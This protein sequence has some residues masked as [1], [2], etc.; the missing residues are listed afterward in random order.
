LKLLASAGVAASRSRRYRLGMP[1]RSGW[2]RDRASGRGSR[3]WS[4]ESRVIAIIAAL[5]ML[6][7]GAA[8]VAHAVSAGDEQEA[9]LP[10][11]VLADFGGVTRA[12]LETNALPYKVVATA[13][14]MREE[15][16]RGTT[17]GRADLPDV[18]RQFG[19][20]TPSRIA[21]WPATVPPPHFD[22]PVGM[23]SAV[24][25][26]PLPLVRIDA[27]NLGCATCHA[28]VL[29]DST[30]RPTSE[31]WAGFPNSSI[32]LE[33]Y[34]QAV[35]VALASAVRDQGAFRARVAE[36][37]PEM[38]RSERITLRFFLLPRVARRIS[39]LREAGFGALPFSNGGAGRTNGVASLKLM[40][41]VPVGTATGHTLHG[42]VGFTSVPDL[43]SRGLRRSLL[44]DG[45]YAP[46]G[47]RARSDVTVESTAVT[48]S[49]LDSLSDIVAFFTVSTMGVTPD[50][51]ER[52]IPAMRPVMRWLAT[53]YASPPF[54]G[55]VDSTRM[56]AGERVFASRCAKCHGTYGEGSPRRLVSFPNA[57]IEQ[58]AMRT[59]STRWAM[60]DSQV[61]A[62]LG[63][64]AYGR[65]MRAERTG[66][67]V[68][69]I[70]SGVWATAPYLHNGSVPTMWQLLTP[71]ERP[72]RFLV[73]GHPLDFRELGIAG[74]RWSDDSYRYPGGYVPWAIPELFDTSRPGMS[75]RGHERPSAGMSAE[76]KWALIEYLKTL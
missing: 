38:S 74:V 34:T 46:I 73:G 48:R 62:R 63:Q 66:G 56:R 8:V 5:A 15:R 21:N 70:L 72:A 12:T 16:V 32:N 51:G 64:S 61:L 59:D 53:E 75:N 43:S 58:D 54:P 24:V 50:A 65:H 76:E 1:N 67:Y 35:F 30:G 41:G 55:H 57:L 11:F 17:L 37:F 47:E 20:L 44:Y 4:A 2:G 28:G 22:R 18:Y 71:K 69:P 39:E 14:I 3:W 7:T 25:R 10:R 68:A 27:V 49:H 19:F 29:Y 9:G 45:V 36:L 33:A 42:D 52:V 60:V 26:G 6:L 13:L 23:V 31:A 40:L